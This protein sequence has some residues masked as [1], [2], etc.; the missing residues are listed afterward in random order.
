M[1]AGLDCLERLSFSRQNINKSLEYERKIVMCTETF[2]E[3]NQSN[4]E[5]KG[6]SCSEIWQHSPRAP[7]LPRI[8]PGTFG[9]A[10]RRK[11]RRV[12]PRWKTKK[13]VPSM[14][15]PDSIQSARHRLCIASP[16]QYS[17]LWGLRQ[18]S[19]G[20]YRLCLLFLLGIQ[21]SDKYS[22]WI[23]LIHLQLYKLQASI[24]SRWKRVIC[25]F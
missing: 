15:L 17:L 20:I 24:Y 3:A 22:H 9:L 13:R 8:H 25:L 2:I 11:I 10:E 12:P 16:R 14:L 4:L 5:T 21:V 19:W 23:H 18:R 7:H 1:S 6:S